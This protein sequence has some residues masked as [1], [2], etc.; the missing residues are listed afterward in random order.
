MT[1]SQNVNSEVYKC[2]TAENVNRVADYINNPM[3][4]TWFSKTENE[5]NREII[6][7]ELIYYWMIALGIPFECQKWHFNR[8]LT[9]IRICKIK[10]T[11]PKKKSRREIARN[12]A[13][14][15]AARRNA[16]K[17]KSR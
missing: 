8:L 2:L 10:N 11:P 5:L 9:L 12:H 13:A 14:I 3:T 6:T 7:T 15:N 1:L 4:A 16:A 17:A